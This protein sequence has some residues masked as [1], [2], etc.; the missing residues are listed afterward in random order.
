MKK[1]SLK[2]EFARTVAVTMLA[3]AL[4]SG[5]AIFGCS[6]LQK[7][8]LPDSNEAWLTQRITAA[9]GTVSEAT[10]R[11]EIGG[12]AQSLGRLVQDGAEGDPD[13]TAS[14]TIDRIDSSFSMLTDK[15]KAAYRISQ[16][17]MVGLPL[18]FAILGIAL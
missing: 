9:D 7:S 5:L 17:A 6:Q 4:A 12:Q 10:T 2:G 3:V 14:Y 15:A 16:V 13:Q 18:L 11:V 1:K 8:I